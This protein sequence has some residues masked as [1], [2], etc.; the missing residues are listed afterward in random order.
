MA[1]ETQSIPKP[2]T[3]RASTR[4]K[5]SAQDT[6]N[7][8][9]AL[10]WLDLE[11]ELSAST[12]Q[13][14]DRLGNPNLQ[15]VQR[16]GL[17]DRIGRVQGNQ[18][19]QQV[20][21]VVSRRAATGGRVQRHAEGAGLSVNKDAAVNQI[22]SPGTLSP[23][24]PGAAPAGTG[25]PAAAAAEAAP[26]TGEAPAPAVGPEAAGTAPAT[27]TAATGAMSLATAQQVLTQSYGGMTTIVPGNIVL[28][29]DRPATWTRYD[30][31]NRGR[32]NPYA[33]RP[34][35]DGDAQQYIPGLDGFA[36]GGTVYVNQQ[37]ELTT[38]TAHEILHNNTAG[39]FRSTVGETINEGTT[40]FLAKKAV[41]AAGIPLS[42]TA[43]AYPTQVSFVEKL[44]ALVGE[45][46]LTS[47][48]FGGAGILVEAYE[49]YHGDDS[50]TILRGF[51]EA[52]NTTAADP[53]LQPPSTEQKI[54]ALNSILDEW[55]VS[56]NDM[57]AMIGIIRTA[58][59]AE[60]EAIRTAIQPRITELSD[61]GQRTQLRVALGTV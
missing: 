59:G 19:L 55:W 47:A 51:A 11:S 40:E 28:L 23:A 14:A 49:A 12:G 1:K 35:Q 53:L 6:A 58:S 8:Q 18:H 4:P 54:A 57:S 17:A 16:Q 22:E 42:T 15:A 37:T 34:W 27:G 52:L 10:E 36:D 21:R 7:P 26:V 5:P 13:Q 60:L 3:D 2:A 50:F 29:A 48:Y 39:D 20:L 46:T 30:E 24:S 33:N 56:G 45:G 41:V 25:A 61:I 44:I 38:A 43:V 9:G 32:N 31:V